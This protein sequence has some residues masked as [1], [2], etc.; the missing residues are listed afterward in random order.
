MA[1]NAFL[2]KLQAEQ[3]R[4]NKAV[5]DLTERWTMQAALDAAIITLG[6]G[7][8]MGG[9]TWGAKRLEAFGDEFVQNL[10]WVVTGARYDP[11]A[12]GVRSE[13]DK[14]LKKKIPHRFGPWPMRYVHWIEP[15]LEEEAAQN[16]SKWKKEGMN[17]DGSITDKLLK[18]LKEE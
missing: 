10:L 17:T 15:T 4:K 2:K 9:D 7:S 11:G 1:K 16:R 5:G 13:V 14:L 18:D 3:E 12:D 8:C 6:Y